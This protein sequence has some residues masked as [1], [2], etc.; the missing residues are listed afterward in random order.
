MCHHMREKIP[1]LM[2]HSFFLPR[3]LK[4][5]LDFFPTVDLV[6]WPPETRNF[7]DGW[8]GQNWVGILVAGR[9]EGRGMV[10]LK[11]NGET[12]RFKRWERSGGGG[13][14][15]CGTGYGMVRLKGNGET[16]VS[17]G[18]KGR[19][20]GWP[21]TNKNTKNASTTNHQPPIFTPLLIL[22][23]LFLKQ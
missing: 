3:P 22:L 17:K 18:R 13:G 19:V 8:G 9:I 15:N 11:G 10:R 1:H 6:L 7:G 12:E 16:G 5:K 2:A 20:G 21:S 14:R 4:K 23:V